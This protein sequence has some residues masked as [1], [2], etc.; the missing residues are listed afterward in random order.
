M[1]VKLDDYY[2]NV[3]I[4][5]L[6]SQSKSYDEE[7]KYQINTL[8]LRLVNISDTIKLN[9]KKKIT[10]EPEETS[11]IIHCLTDWLNNQIRAE[12]L[13][14]AEVIGELLMKFTG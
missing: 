4:N 9:R 11:L 13:T 3:L 12:K 2:L 5:G 8:I 6:Y 10:F 1:K 7:T 14:A